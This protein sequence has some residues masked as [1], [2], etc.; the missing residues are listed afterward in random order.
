M[1]TCSIYL[2]WN[3]YVAIIEGKANKLKERLAGAR[4]SNQCRVPFSSEIVIEAAAISHSAVI[5]NARFDQISEITGDLYFVHDVFQRGFRIEHS[6]MVY[7]TVT[8][9]SFGLNLGEL[10]ATSIPFDL[11]KAGRNAL[12]LSPRELNNVSP[13]KAIEA[14]DQVLLSPEN[15][16]NYAEYDGDL[17]FKGILRTVDRI[18]AEHHEPTQRK[19]GFDVDL[20]RSS[21]PFIMGFSLFDSFGFWPDKRVERNKGSMLADAMHAFYGSCCDFIVSEDRRFRMKAEATYSLMGSK[22]RVLDL[23]LALEFL[24]SIPFPER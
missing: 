24:R 17:S 13:D 3:I 19:W 21:R 23:Q 14:I 7:Q 8:Q 1:K 15:K 16:A 12:G 22:T 18:H 2:D 5:R 11:M 6:S 9:G 4:K 10:F 20:D